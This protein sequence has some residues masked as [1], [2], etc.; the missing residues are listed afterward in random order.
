MKTN[1]AGFPSL[2]I[3]VTLLILTS[4]AIDAEEAQPFGEDFPKL[5]NAATGE[6][7]KTAQP[8]AKGAKKNKAPK[9]IVDMNVPRDQTVAF[10]VYTHENAILKLSAQ[11]YPLKPDEPREARLEFKRDGK[12]VEAAREKVL[13]PGWSA[14]FRIEDWDNSKDVAY[15]VRHG[16]EAEFEGLIRRDP[17]EKDVI[18]VGNLSCNSSS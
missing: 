14:H 16:E 15:R 6:W 8:A 10:A 11:L 7:W 12:W 17:I 1:S 2:S 3:V 9:K 5:D 13:Y 18:V 4:A